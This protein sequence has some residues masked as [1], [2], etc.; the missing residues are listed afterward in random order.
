MVVGIL[1]RGEPFTTVC[2]GT[3][4]I[5]SNKNFLFVQ[6]TNEYC[7]NDMRSEMSSPN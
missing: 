1:L 7:R 4:I 3:R 2:F 6:N 5:L